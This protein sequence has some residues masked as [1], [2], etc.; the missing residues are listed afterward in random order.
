MRSDPTDQN[1]RGDPSDTYGR[2]KARR[3]KNQAATNSIDPRFQ[4]TKCSDHEWGAAP[5]QLR[6]LLHRQWACT[7]ADLFN[8]PITIRVAVE[9][10][11]IAEAVSR[12]ATVVGYSRALEIWCGGL[13]HPSTADAAANPRGPGGRKGK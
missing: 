6:E 8:E 3:R 4:G 11:F 1:Q 5:S 12:D 2:L 7:R 10:V 9:T 13:A